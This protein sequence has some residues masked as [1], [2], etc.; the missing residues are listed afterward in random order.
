MRHAVVECRSERYL[1]VDDKPPPPAWDKI[2]GVYRVRDGRFVRLHTNFPA[3]PRRRLQGAR[4]A[5]PS[6]TRS[7]PRCCNGMA[8]RSR[9]RPMPRAASLP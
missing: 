1:R 9:P 2:A 3:S 4:A 7:R 5:T 8:R 6:A